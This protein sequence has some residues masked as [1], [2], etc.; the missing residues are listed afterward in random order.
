MK[1]AF[2]KYLIL[3]FLFAYL[4]VCG[5]TLHLGFALEYS[6]QTCL[7]AGINN[8]MEFGWDNY[9]HWFWNKID[10]VCRFNDIIWMT[11]NW[12]LI[13]YYGLLKF[14]G[15][16]R[17]L[18]TLSLYYVIPELVVYMLMYLSNVTQTNIIWSGDSLLNAMVGFVQLISPLIMIAFLS[19]IGKVVFDKANLQYLWNKHY[20][21]YG[22]IALLF[23]SVLMFPVFPSLI[24]CFWVMPIGLAYIYYIL[25]KMLN[26]II[27]GL[28]AKIDL[29]RRITLLVVAIV[30]FVLENYALFSFSDEMIYQHFGKIFFINLIIHSLYYGISI[31]IMSP[32]KI[33]QYLYNIYR[34]GVDEGRNIWTDKTLRK[35]LPNKK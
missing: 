22:S 25:P 14:Y 35:D 13:S 24:W 34:L 11:Y 2:L 23:S 9:F 19:V 17:G 30:F 16:R 7:A 26:N 28:S 27:L 10:N 32:Q 4:L 29:Y 21:I 1:I 20:K 33:K 15:I 8:Y 31:S 6:E 18:N 12:L 5:Y 3:D